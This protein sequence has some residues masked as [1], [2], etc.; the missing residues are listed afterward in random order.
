MYNLTYKNNKAILILYI[1]YKYNTC[2]KVLSISLEKEKRAEKPALK[3]NPGCRSYLLT[4][5]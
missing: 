2:N 3:F 1:K 5:S 4:P